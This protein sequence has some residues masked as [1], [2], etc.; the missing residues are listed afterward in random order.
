MVTLELLT[1][2]KTRGVKLSIQAG[3]LTSCGP[4]GAITPDLGEQIKAQKA[5][6]LEFLS[7]PMTNTQ[8]AE[9]VTKLDDLNAPDWPALARQPGHCGSCARF[10]HSPDWG[11]YL[12][13]CGAQARAWWPDMA[14]LSIH[15]AHT[16]PIEGVAGYYAKAHP[17]TEGC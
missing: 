7:L 13:K 6:L 2:L 11:P 12:G 9:V 3:Q 1:A 15:L 10:T 14:P 5:S 4:V 16:C 8:S 17:L